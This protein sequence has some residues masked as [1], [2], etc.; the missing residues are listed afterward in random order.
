MI[1]LYVADD[2]DIGSVIN[3]QQQPQQ[4]HLEHVKY[5]RVLFKCLREDLNYY[6][7][8]FIMYNNFC[9]DSEN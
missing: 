1:L 8:T 4:Q 6:I 3:Q 7:L 5:K 9:L 2:V